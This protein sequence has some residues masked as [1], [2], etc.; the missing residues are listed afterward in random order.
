MALL[1]L[2]PSF[3]TSMLL[4]LGE[5]PSLYLA[6]MPRFNY[7]SYPAIVL[8]AASAIGVLVQFWLD[9]NRRWL[10]GL[11]AGLPLL[12]CAVLSNVDAFGFMPR[13]YYHFYWNSGGYFG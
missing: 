2:L 1:L 6:G 10:A 11:S 8:L 9:R 13:L 3:A 7:P 5:A 12:A 4:Y